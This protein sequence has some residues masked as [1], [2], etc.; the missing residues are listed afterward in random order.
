MRV[1]FSSLSLTW[2]TPLAAYRLLDTEFQFD[3]DPCPPNYKIDGLTSEWGD[4]LRR[5]E[6]RQDRS[7]VNT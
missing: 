5:M 6:E 2:R 4:G 7:N 1:H 3:H